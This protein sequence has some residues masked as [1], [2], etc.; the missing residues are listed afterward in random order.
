MLPIVYG[1]SPWLLGRVPLKT[2]AATMKA[3]ALTAEQ[4]Q[5]VR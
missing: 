5:T 3:G 1:L 2:S 4:W